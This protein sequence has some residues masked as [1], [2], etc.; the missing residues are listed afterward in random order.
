MTDASAISRKGP[1]IT[2]DGP[3]GA[4]KSTMARLLA[5]RLGF[6]LLDTGALYRAVAL[7]LIRLG[8]TADDDPILE[9][10]LGSV[11]LK[12]EPGVASMKLFLGEE[13]VSHIIRSERIGDAA[14]KFSAKP[15]VRRALLA[16]QRCAASRGRVVA[17]G[18][19]MGTVV[20]PD[21]EVK[22]F[23]VADLAERSKRRHSEVLAGNERVKLSKVRSEM[24][25]RDLRDESRDQAPLVKA[26]DA[27]VIDTTLLNPTQVLQRMEDHIA[28]L[29]PTIAIGETCT[30]DRG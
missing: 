16:I 29:L 30:G 2:I 5:G 25:T 6:C 18:R 17:E 10:A 14:S 28:R 12:V 9:S 13:E 7:H 1:V 8:L 15:E 20:F 21:A 26:R 24:Q 4:G 27:L 19:D 3:A 23:L 11:N 22:F